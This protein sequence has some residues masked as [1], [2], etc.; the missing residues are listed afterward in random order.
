MNPTP[1]TRTSPVV[2]FAL[3]TPILAFLLSCST[4]HQSTGTT[5][6][7]AGPT[8]IIQDEHAGVWMPFDNFFTKPA[9]MT[10]DDFKNKRAGFLFQSGRFFTYLQN[11]SIEYYDE[12]NTVNFSNGIATVPLVRGIDWDWINIVGD[13]PGY[14]DPPITWD[15]AG[16][17]FPSSVANETCDVG[18]GCVQKDN[19]LAVPAA[20]TDTLD[21]Q[22]RPCVRLRSIHAYFQPMGIITYWHGKNGYD[23]SV[24]RRTGETCNMV[25]FKLKDSIKI[26]IWKGGTRYAAA[27]DKLTP[28]GSNLTITIVQPPGTPHEDT[29]DPPTGPKP[30]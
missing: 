14:Q 10:K 4:H 12:A 27:E 2:I 19:P 17:L 1:S 25:T 22:P 13:F 28:L 23:M 3:T 20:C 18:D 29:E 24:A 8:I 16:L 11:N 30:K 26:E 21:K 6:P 9:G 7:I 5:T 15:Y